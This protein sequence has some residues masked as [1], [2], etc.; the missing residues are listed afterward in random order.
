MT[1]VH[2]GLSLQAVR[3]FQRVVSCSKGVAG[4]TIEGF[5]EGAAGL[6]RD[7]TR[8]YGLTRVL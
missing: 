6:V 8:V 5:Q 2:K 4:V 7:T 3:V 1:W